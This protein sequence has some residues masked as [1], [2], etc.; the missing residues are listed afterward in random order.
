MAP[1][2]PT[3]AGECL[4]QFTAQSMGTAGNQYMVKLGH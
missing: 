3:R 1:D 4:N 2:M